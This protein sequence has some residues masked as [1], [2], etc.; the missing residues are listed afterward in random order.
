MKINEIEIRD[1]MR[2]ALQG[3]IDKNDLTGTEK[4]N[5]LYYA[6][7]DK[8]KALHLINELL[9]SNPDKTFDYFQTRSENYID[10]V[11]LI[12][13][14]DPFEIKNKSIKFDG[15]KELQDEV[16]KYLND[17]QAVTKD[18]LELRSRQI[19]K[20]LTY[21]KMTLAD[22]DEY[23][24]IITE[25]LARLKQFITT[26]ELMAENISIRLEKYSNQQQ[27]QPDQPQKK[28]SE[29]I[30]YQWTKQP[31]TQLPKLYSRLISGGFI[32]PETSSETFTACFTGQ[33]VKDISEKIQWLKETALLVYFI[34]SLIRG[35]MVNKKNKW[36]IATFIFDLVTNLKQTAY[37]IQKF[38]NPKGSE[39]IEDVL[40]DL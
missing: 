34:D 13:W 2:Q 10:A 33:P 20:A 26:Y 15:T 19:R 27:N 39:L 38:G 32:G 31:G 25:D 5:I 18:G 3:R 28:T 36:L 24:H 29:P 30:T 22:P 16:N 23:N 12:N 14:L 9:Q 6:R 40:K 4:A 11:K 37:N 8:L 35:K 1:L 21:F 17:W 7:Q